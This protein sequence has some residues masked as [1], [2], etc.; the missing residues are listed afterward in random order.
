MAKENTKAEILNNI[1]N[2]MSQVYEYANSVIEDDVVENNTLDSIANNHG[3]DIKESIRRIA[4][5]DANTNK[6]LIESLE[7]FA[8]AINQGAYDECLCESYISTLSQ[9]KYLLPVQREFDRINEAM[10]ESKESIN[11]AKILEQMNNSSSYYIVPMIEEDAIRYAKNPTPMNRTQLR[12]ILCSFAADPFCN[13][14][15]EAIELDGKVITNTL[16]EKAMSIK[17]QIKVIRQNASVNAIY[18]PVQYIKENES[19]FNVRGQF[20]VKKGA[21]LAKLN[22][23]YVDQ[24]SE[25]FVTL[26]KLVND[27]HVSI[28]EDSITVVTNN[29]VANI[30]EGYAEINGNREDLASIKNMNIMGMKYDYDKNFYNAVAMLMENFDNIANINFAKHISLNE[31]ENVSADI[32]RIGDNIFINT[33]NENVDKSTFY[34]NV[35]PIQC[36]NIINKHMNINV[37]AIFED[38]LPSQDKIMLRLNETK[39][40][41][42]A[43]IEKYEATI[44]KLKKAKTEGMS[45]DSASKLDS[46]IETATKKVDELKKEYKE[47]QEQVEKNTK[48]KGKSTNP[49]DDDIEDDDNTEVEPTNEPI[50]ADDVEDAKPELQEPINGEDNNSGLTFDDIEDAEDMDVDDE[51][52]EISDDEFAS[53]LDDENG[54]VD[55]NAEDE[56]DMED[57]EE[58]DEEMDAQIDTTV[59]DDDDEWTEMDIDD[60]DEEIITDTEDTEDTE[61]MDDMEDMDDT[62][63][64]FTVNDTDEDIVDAET[65]LTDIPD[66]YK[67]AEVKFDRNVRTGELFKTGKVVVL[68]TMLGQ[69]G[70]MYLENNEYSFYIDED[71][72]KPIVDIFDVPVAL[73]NAI[74]N[75]IV[76]DEKFAEAVSN[77]VVKD[78]VNIST[79][80]VGK[81]IPNEEIEDEEEDEND[82]LFD[83]TTDTEDE[84]ALTTADDDIE[85]DMDDEATTPR[86]QKRS[87]NDLFADMEGGETLDD[88]FGGEDEDIDFESDED[89]FSADETED[90]DDFVAK[91]GAHIPTYK[92]GDTEIELPASNVDD[93]LIPEDET[94][95][96]KDVVD[97][98]L[99]DIEKKRPIKESMGILGMRPVYKKRNG[100]FV[101]DG[102]IKP[103]KKEVAHVN[104]ASDAN[105][106]SVD[107]KNEVPNNMKLM[108][109]VAKK[110]MALASARAV[111]LQVSGIKSVYSDLPYFTISNY[112]QNYTVYAID[113]D[114]YYR[115]TREFLSILDNPRFAESEL[116]TD[117]LRNSYDEGLLDCVSVDNFDDCVFTIHAILSS[118][119][120]DANGIDETVKI[121]KAGLS[122]EGDFEKTKF[123]DDI[124]YGDEERRDFEEKIEKETQKNGLE[125][126]LAPS[127]QQ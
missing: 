69:D 85:L 87:A 55:N 66:G 110:A 118:L 91:R 31:D 74:V 46:A 114:M 39:N 9:Y 45:E 73:Y 101:N 7:R 71:T 52:D 54:D 123:V 62:T 92:S 82:Q 103:S 6:R 44:E 125:N 116:L 108:C 76:N 98:V 48:G 88:M 77:G 70:Q 34:H 22:N 122:A 72:E 20:Y 16:E 120:V 67:I 109:A 30:Y 42:E 50:D 32:F 21:S 8:G 80:G 28:N 13:Q 115:P 106:G 14:M 43:S 57:T 111:N 113:N 112:D 102:T 36:R 19:V 78:D 104:E 17:D 41:Y 23:T 81:F 68:T 121:A 15:L 61:D 86:Q 59:G 56:L 12:N 94:E 29:K 53:Y 3:L 24:L 100:F 79:D 38:L 83:V 89:D 47:W 37:S 10:K 107:A 51:D 97:E 127:A 49:V 63:D 25:K 5:S 2:M 105:I 96:N 84:F 35:N 75:A 18:S 119:G 99:R 27:P 26:C 11:V 1:Q 4:S 60:N 33:I 126:P 117:L 40:E 124:L 58:P 65:L 90:E 64:T 95:E 93:T